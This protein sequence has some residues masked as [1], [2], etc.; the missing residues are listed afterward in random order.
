MFFL[1]RDEIFPDIRIFAARIS[2]KCAEAGAPGL[3]DD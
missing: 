1:A 2:G 3:A